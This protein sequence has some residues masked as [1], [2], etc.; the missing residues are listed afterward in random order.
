MLKLSRGEGYIPPSPAPAN[1]VMFVPTSVPVNQPPEALTPSFF[2][3]QDPFSPGAGGG[4]TIP[5]TTEESGPSL[6]GP[7][8][9]QPAQPINPTSDSPRR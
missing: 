6:R 2:Q 8:L 7:M 3:P 5:T 4:Q 1:T 9:Q